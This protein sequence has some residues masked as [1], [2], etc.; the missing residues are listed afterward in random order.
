MSAPQVAFRI[1]DAAKAN[2]P[3]AALT[4][5]DAAVV[6]GIPLRPDS[7]NSL[8]YLC[9]GGEHW[10]LP[11]DATAQRQVPTLFSR[12]SPMKP[13]PHPETHPFQFSLVPTLTLNPVLRLL[14]KLLAWAMLVWLIACARGAG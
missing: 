7:F 8:L 1:R 6:E 14:D 4:A 12:S 10:A 11:G 3:A 5:Y 2:D 9:A 13:T